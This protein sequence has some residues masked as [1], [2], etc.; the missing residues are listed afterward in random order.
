MSTPQTIGITQAG[1]RSLT[2]T[3]L[4]EARIR[5][6]ATVFSATTD[7]APGWAKTP[8]GRYWRL[9][10]PPSVYHALTAGDAC[11][12]LW[13]GEDLLGALDWDARE[14]EPN[15]TAYQVD[16]ELA[17]GHITELEGEV[18]C[19]ATGKRA[20]LGR[21]EADPDNEWWLVVVD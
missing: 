2:L 4:E 21:V 9:D 6:Y 15:A 10:V 18:T 3:I 14:Q 11:G 17:G 1:R 16:P 20:L 8:D 13:R 19:T 12:V 5:F 7:D